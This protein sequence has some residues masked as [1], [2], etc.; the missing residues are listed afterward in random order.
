MEEDLYDELEEQTEQAF[1]YDELEDLSENVKTASECDSEDES[2]IKVS[3]A[4]K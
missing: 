1:V 2:R 4:N 3:L